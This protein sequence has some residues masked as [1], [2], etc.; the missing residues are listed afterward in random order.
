ML[1]NRCSRYSRDLSGSLSLLEFKVQLLS[2]YQASETS[3]VGTLNI[4][5]SLSICLLEVNT[6]I[7]TTSK[8]IPQYI[9]NY[10]YIGLGVY[11]MQPELHA[12]LQ[13]CIPMTFA[14]SIPP[15]QA[16]DSDNAWFGGRFIKVTSKPGSCMMY[17][18]HKPSHSQLRVRVP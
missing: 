14:Q 4:E 11:V 2:S 6:L 5:L 1:S 17:S 8:Y 13:G 9:H 16:P 15:T 18:L 7:D 10:F 3:K 12:T